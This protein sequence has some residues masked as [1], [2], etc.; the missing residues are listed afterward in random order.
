MDMYASV[1]SHSGSAMLGVGMDMVAGIGVEYH[2]S[3]VEVTNTE[4]WR[5]FRPKLIAWQARHGEVTLFGSSTSTHPDKHS[6]LIQAL[7]C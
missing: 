5:L 6:A 3:Q 7:M 1:G 2:S 4:K